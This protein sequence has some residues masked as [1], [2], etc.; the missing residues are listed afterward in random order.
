MNFG[1]IEHIS[2]KKMRKKEKNALYVN[3]ALQA[4]TEWINIHDLK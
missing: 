2:G 4:L 3:K 1:I